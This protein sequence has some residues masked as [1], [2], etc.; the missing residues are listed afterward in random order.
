VPSDPVMRCG[1]HLLA[2]N[3]AVPSYGVGAAGVG[4]AAIN[5]REKLKKFVQPFNFLNTQIQRY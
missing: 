2:I 4:D 5:S 1:T 3:R